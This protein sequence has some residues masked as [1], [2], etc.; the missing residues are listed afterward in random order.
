MLERKCGNKLADECSVK[1]DEKLRENMKTVTQALPKKSLQRRFLLSTAAAS[2][3]SQY[4]KTIFGIWN[5][6]MIASRKRFD[7][8][9]DRHLLEPDIFHL[10]LYDDF[11]IQ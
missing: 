2:Y 8:L 11:T 7:Y 5:R 9:K 10:V 3:R 1:E 6:E 4:L